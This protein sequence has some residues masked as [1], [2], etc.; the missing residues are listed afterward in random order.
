MTH[1]EIAIVFRRNYVEVPEMRRNEE[2]EEY[3]ARLLQVYLIIHYMH[4]SYGG[5]AER[6]WN[7]N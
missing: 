1:D 2:E 7:G 3:T 6:E 4:A 5:M